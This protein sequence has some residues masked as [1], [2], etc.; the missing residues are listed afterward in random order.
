MVVKPIKDSYTAGQ[1]LLAVVW[2]EALNF[3]A[4]LSANRQSINYLLNPL[5]TNSLVTSSNTN[6]ITAGWGDGQLMGIKD[7]G[8][9]YW[10]VAHIQQVYYKAYPAIGKEAAIINPDIQNKASIIV[11]Q[12]T[13]LDLIPPG[14]LNTKF[15][16]SKLRLAHSTDGLNWQIMPSSVVDTANNTVAAIGR[17]GGYYAIVGRY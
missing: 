11:F 16:E 1:A 6:V 17:V 8:T 12:Y 7:Q 4:Y 9:I 13:D 5:G 3:N 15:T 14:Q 2:P 10:Q